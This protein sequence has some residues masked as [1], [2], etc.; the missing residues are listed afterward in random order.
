MN[1]VIDTFKSYGFDLLEVDNKTGGFL[2]K[3][4]RVCIY[5]F[6]NGAYEVFKNAFGGVCYSH[7]IR[8]MTH[9]EQVLTKVAEIHGL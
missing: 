6:G 9:P 4:D 5:H 8:K 2:M 7:L 3:K 1:T